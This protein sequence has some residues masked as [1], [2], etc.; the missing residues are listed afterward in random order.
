MPAEDTLTY[1]IEIDPSDLGAQLDQIR[2]QVNLA[3]GAAAFSQAP[4]PPGLDMSFSALPSYI[5]STAGSF[6]G[7]TQQL[8]GSTEANLSNYLNHNYDAFKL[9]YS[10]FTTGM[11]RM[12]LMVPPAPMISFP[13]QGVTEF[14]RQMEAIQAIG[15]PGGRLF[16]ATGL[17]NVEMPGLVK[18]ALGFG[19]DPNK[20]SFSRSEF[21][22]RYGDALGTRVTGMLERNTGMLAGAAVG[23]VVP[24]VGTF[25]GSIV[26]MGYDMTMGWVGQQRQQEEQ[27]GGALQA[28]SKQTLMPAALSQR[29]GTRMAENLLGVADSYESRINKLTRD[30]IQTELLE[31]TK[32]GGFDATRSVDEFE[33]VAK[34]VIANTRK[35]MQSLRMTQEEAIKMMADMQ[36]EGLVSTGDASMFALD[37][38]QSAKASGMDSMELM[39]FMRQ[40]AEMYRGSGVGMQ[41]GMQMLQEARLTVQDMVQDTGAGL[42]IARELGGTSNAAAALAQGQTN[43][44]QTAMGLVQYNNMQ[45]GG[46]T[47]DMIGAMGNMSGMNAFDVYRMRYNIDQDMGSGKMSPQEMASFQIDPYLDRYASTLRMTEGRGMESDDYEGFMY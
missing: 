12:G 36:R 35:V 37:I 9:G 22:Q 32:A 45:Q 5:E 2:S 6:A 19:Y 46:T 21:N 20:M 41:G 27:V 10:K 44:M 8:A 3:M 30:D 47:T 17:E 4:A 42:T 38:A 23:S 28:I 24:G 39:N 18:G 43:F 34:G 16:T 14:T 25:A 29:E 31:F 1:K 26:G 15:Q 33:S 7:T 13:Q 40:G 11:E